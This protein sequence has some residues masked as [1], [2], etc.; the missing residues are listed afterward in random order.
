MTLQELLGT[1]AS[2]TGLS[3]PTFR[4]PTSVSLAAAWASDFVEA[5][6][7]RRE[8]H[9]PLEGARM[10]ATQMRYDDSRARTELGFTSRPSREA[11]L[12][13]VR[14]FI[15]TDR[16]TPGRLAKLHVAETA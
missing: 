3:A 11:L 6:L 7:L 8:P 5:G 12:D 14:Y 16:V 4:V 1:L 2:L 13:A 15:A 9:V 10:S